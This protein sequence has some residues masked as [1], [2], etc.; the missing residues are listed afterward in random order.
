MLCLDPFAQPAIR[1][2]YRTVRG[3]TTPLSVHLGQLLV[4]ITCQIGHF[5]FVLNNV[6]SNF[7]PILPTNV[8]QCR[9]VVPR[10][11]AR[12]GFLLR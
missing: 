5:A 9:F 8:A 3:Q 2:G 1:H 12:Y 11:A 7:A 4:F 10:F 6:Q